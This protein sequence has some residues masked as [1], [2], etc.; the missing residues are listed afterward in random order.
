MFEAKIKVDKSLL[1]RLQ[2][3]AD[4]QGYSSVNEFVVHVLE[5]IAEPSE[6]SD[7]EDAVKERL[8]GLGYID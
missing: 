7:S 6:N 1:D 4:A 2:V 5:Q 8:R 3:V